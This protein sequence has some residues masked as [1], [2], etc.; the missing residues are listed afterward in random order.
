MRRPARTILTRLLRAA[1]ITDGVIRR[2][3]FVAAACA[4]LVV[5]YGRPAEAATPKPKPS[6]TKGV[7]LINTNLALQN[8]SAAGTGI[9]LTKTG[10]VMT[11]NHVIAG[12]TTI[13]V[14]VPATKRT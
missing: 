10:E 4:A 5:A 14:T 9:V 6:P 13:Q 2:I 8:G 11:N 3:A 7:V 12:A 1:A